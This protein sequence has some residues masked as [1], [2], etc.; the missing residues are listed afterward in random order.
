MFQVV[1]NKSCAATDAFALIVEGWNELVQEGFTADRVATPPISS[2]TE[3][4]YAVNS[5][6]YGGDIVGVLAFDYVPGRNVYEVGL[7][8]V[9]ISSRRQGVFKGLVEALR[10]HAHDTGVAHL[11]FDVTPNN[12]VALSALKAVGL[13]PERVSYV[14]DV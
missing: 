10:V 6:S 8:Y 13:R 11:V 4:L 2:S 3:V 1:Y 5:D 14:C 7:C 9:E 12:A